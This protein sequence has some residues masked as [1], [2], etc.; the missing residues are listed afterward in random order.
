[1]TLDPGGIGKGLAADLVV[2]S[3]LAKGAEGVLVSLGGDLAAAGTSPTTDGW[4]V[5][6]EDPLDTERVV[7]TVTISGGGVATSS[8][9]IRRWS[10]PDG[11]IHHHV[12]D[13]RTGRP[14]TTDLAA[15][16]VVA[17]CGWQAEAAATALLLSGTAGLIADARTL[18]RRRGRQRTPLA[19]RSPPR[20]SNPSLLRRSSA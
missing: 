1:M 2:A 11:G 18:E 3:L 13:P 8:T 19:P 14:S 17:P 16:T 10:A 20:G 9:T 5:D 6:I 7:R 12:I 15:V 4:L